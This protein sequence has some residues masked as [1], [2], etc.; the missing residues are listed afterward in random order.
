[1]QARKF[2]SSERFL[3]KTNV[4]VFGNVARRQW[5]GEVR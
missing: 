4:E 3:S 2:G 5:D 1:M